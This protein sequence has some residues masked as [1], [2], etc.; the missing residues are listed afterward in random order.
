[1]RVRVGKFDSRYVELYLKLKIA[2][3][4]RQKLSTAVEGNK[5]CVLKKFM[6]E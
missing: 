4:W 6:W 1:M 3:R 2:T 5:Y